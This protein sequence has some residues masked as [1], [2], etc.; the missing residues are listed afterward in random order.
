MFGLAEPLVAVLLQRVI[1][2]SPADM[3]APGRDRIAT[4]R[5]WQVGRHPR[6]RFSPLLPAS[7]NSERRKLGWTSLFSLLSGIW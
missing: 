5:A 3:Q 7:C 2:L 4:S 6:L 1:M